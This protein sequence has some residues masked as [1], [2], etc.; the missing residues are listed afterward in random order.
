MRI[1]SIQMNPVVGAVVENANRIIELGKQAER[2]GAEVIV[3]PELALIGYPPEDLVERNDLAKFAGEELDRVAEAAANACWIIGHASYEDGKVFNSASVLYDGAIQICYHK[4]HLPNYDVFDEVRN[5][6]YG[7]ESCVFQYKGNSIG[8]NICEDIWHQQPAENAKQ[9]GAEIILVLNASPFAYSKL[10]KRMEQVKLRVTE[11]GL[12][13]CYVN[14]VG[15]QDDLVFDGCSFF[16]DSDQNI[17]Q[18][19]KA[20]TESGYIVDTENPCSLQ[21]AWPASDEAWMYQALVSGTRDYVNKNGFK[22]ALLGLSGGIDSA[23][24][25]CV[26]VDALGAENVHAVM[27][28]YKYTAQMSVEDAKKQAE[29]LGVKFDIVPI[30]PAVSAFSDMLEPLFQGTEKDTTEENLQAR[31]RGVLLMA[32]SNKFG[33]IVLTTGNKSEMATG[34]ATLYGDM[35]GGYA[36]L[37]DVLKNWVYAISRYCNRDGE[38]IPQRVINRPPSAELAPEQVD[39]DSLPDYDVLDDIIERYVEKDESVSDIVAAGHEIE[40]VLRIQ[41]L[42]DI[43][44]YKRRQAA[45]GPKISHRAFGRERRYPISSGFRQIFKNG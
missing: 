45:P 34:Y 19:G 1:A 13:I 3:F 6:S 25:L 20:F 24:T 15:G 43:N 11:T 32:L 5:F 36:V 4:Q 17:F 8:L 21:S 2:D 28:P 27:M 31:S 37:K 10:E 39:Q 14:L 40:T 12:P 44:E 41:R 42:I 16:V 23:L 7:N 26:A 33:K 35:A 18:T 9:L 38:I 29:L 22:G 30:E